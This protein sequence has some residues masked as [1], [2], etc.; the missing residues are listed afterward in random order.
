LEYSYQEKLGEMIYNDGTANNGKDLLG[1]LAIVEDGGNWGTLGGIDASTTNTW[2]R[3]NEVDHDVDWVDPNFAD[4]TTAQEGDVITGI[5]AMRQLYFLCV[6]G[7]QQPDIGLTHVDTFS[8][9]EAALT[10]NQRHT[11][12]EAA[13][14]GFMN[15]KFKNATMFWD[16]EYINPTAGVPGTGGNV[17]LLYFLNSNFLK[18][19]IDTQ[20]NF[21][22]TPFIRPHNQDARS[23]QTLFMGNVVPL[24]RQ[25]HG[26]LWNFA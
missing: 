5:S 23:S 17:G 18:V 25:R 7:N 2:W 14:H 10:S 15:L 3:N 20:T 4:T 6:K 13:R 1:L 26:V 16:S 8:Q 24:N 21:L 22:Q 12:T 19:I 9:Y 11:N